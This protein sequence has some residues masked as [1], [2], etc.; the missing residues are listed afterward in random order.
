MGKGA[1]CYNLRVA[2]TIFH[3]MPILL[4]QLIDARFS[5]ENVLKHYRISPNKR[6]GAEAQKKLSS[7]F[8]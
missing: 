2:P 4:F 6:M 1:N 8:N 3:P 7:D 5:K